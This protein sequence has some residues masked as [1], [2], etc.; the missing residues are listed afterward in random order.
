MVNNTTL[1]MSEYDELL[2][3]IKRRIGTAPPPQL[4]GIAGPPATGKSTLAERLVTD[5]T[6]AGL[7]AALCPMD[8]FHLSNAQ[9]ASIGLT[10]AKGRIDTF[11]SRAFTEAVSWL[12][13]GSAFWWPL[14]CRQRHEPVAEGTR[15]E[16]TEAVYIIEGNY[17]LADAEPWRTAAQMLNLRIFVDTLDTV[18]RER[19]LQRHQQGGRSEQEA[20]QKIDHTDLPN[21]HK[22][23]AERLEVDI[24]FSMAGYDEE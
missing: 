20:L 13:I 5:L 8:G 17:V 16:G 15:I 22:I 10:Q 19:L 3:D 11:D 7:S 21:A 23:R 6:S 18:L 1:C 9:L 4:L 2:I 24:I 14:Y 12:T